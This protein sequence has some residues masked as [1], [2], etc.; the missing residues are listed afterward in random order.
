MDLTEIGQEVVDWIDQAK[1]R[2]QWLTLAPLKAGNFVT[3]FSG[4]TLLHVICWL[5]PVPEE[6][7]RCANLCYSSWNLVQMAFIKVSSCRPNGL[8]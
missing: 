4:R 5:V 7:L 3:S 6:H 8:Y 2:D 1:G